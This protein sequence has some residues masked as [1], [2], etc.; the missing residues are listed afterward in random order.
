MKGL[1]TLASLGGALA[2]VWP[3]PVSYEKGEGV[4]FIDSNVEILYNGGGSVSADEDD[5]WCCG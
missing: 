3:L 5:V 2:S 4:L 1:L